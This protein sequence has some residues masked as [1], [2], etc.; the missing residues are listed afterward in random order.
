MKQTSTSLSISLLREQRAKQGLILEIINNC[1]L[2]FL[3]FI[4]IC[5]GVE[6]IILPPVSSVVLIITGVLGCIV[7][8]LIL[9]SKKYLKLGFLIAAVWIVLFSLIM[10]ADMLNGIRL[11][12]TQINEVMGNRFGKIYPIYDVTV[13]AEWKYFSATLFFIPVCLLFSA[14]CSYLAK[15]KDVWISLILVAVVLSLNLF[16]QVQLSIV[17]LSVLFVAEILLLSQSFETKENFYSDSSRSYISSSIIMVVIFC[18]FAGISILTLSGLTNNIFLN[19]KENLLR[20]VDNIRYGVNTDFGMPDGDFSDLGEYEPSSETAIEVSMETPE[21]LWLRGYVG[22]EYTGNGWK[23]EDKS[24]LFDKAS[25]FYWL[26]ADNF[27]GQNQLA[28]SA[29]VAEQESRETAFAMRVKNLKASSRSVYAPYEL[30][31]ANGEL[32]PIDSIGDSSLHSAGLTGTREYEYTSIPNQVKRYPDIIM[33]L[34]DD[35]N[36]SSPFSDP[37]LVNESHYAKFVTEQYTTLPTDVTKWVEE[38]MKEALPN[39][40]ESSFSSAKQAIIKYLTEEVA[41][42]TNPKLSGTGD[43]AHDFLLLDKQGYSVHYATAATLLFR[44]CGIPSRYVEGFLITPQDVEG[45]SSKS[46]IKLDGKHSHA[47]VEVYQDKV[48]WIPVEVTPPYFGL[49]EEADSLMGVPGADSQ[50]EEGASSSENP[51]EQIDM[52]DSLDSNIFSEKNLWLIIAFLVVLIAV[53][54]FIIRRY[55]KS[56][57]SWLQGMLESFYNNS[58]SGASH[59]MFICAMQVLVVLG[60][61]T[62]GVWL[63]KQLLRNSEDVNNFSM[64]RYSDAFKIYEEATY[65]NREIA[66]DKRKEVE[67]FLKKT[68]NQLNAE[69][70]GLNRLKA[71]KLLKLSTVMS[72]IQ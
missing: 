65:S 54:G 60:F 21:S 69:T 25:L 17:W 27:F 35:E 16:L 66:F 47:W 59:A 31:W 15:V 42:S 29:I 9:S 33:S 20:N 24:T 71:N 46:V 67:S 44:Y 10:H 49:M 61:K 5:G 30:L 56:R 64:E 4:G 12:A 48:G 8:I 53:A 72:E 14:I 70:K 36:N 39:K 63:I 52:P 68:L 34:Y 6:K 2:A 23:S 3:L 13:D 45:L 50:S 62:D 57:Y 1:L 22:S 11:V 32:L 51:E 43:F 37:Y 38:Y 41:Y 55:L 40:E 19:A 18:F 26:H 7:F 58:N 28:S